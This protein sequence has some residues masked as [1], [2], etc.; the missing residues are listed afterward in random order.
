VALSLNYTYKNGQRYGGWVDTGGVY[1]QVPFL[2]N[3]GAEP[4]GKVINVFQ[5]QN[6]V[7]NRRFQ[8]TNREGM[9]SKTNAGIIQI[10]KRMSHNWQ[11]VASAVFTRAEGRL[12]SSL[13]SP[14]AAQSAH[15]GGS[16]GQNPNDLTNSD[17]S[18]IG[19]RPF[20]GKLQLVYQLPKGFLIGANFLHQSGRPWGR[21][22]TVTRTASIPTTILSEQLGD[23]RVGTWNNLDVRLQ[24]EFH[25]NKEANL[26]VFVDGL[27][28]LNGHANEGIASRNA[29]SSS[30]AYPTRFIFPRR[31]ML[32]AKVRF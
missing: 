11:M 16:F 5:L 31:V 27:N 28:I 19:E 1:K 25:F 7:A 18:L 13:G 3:V 14:T 10:T 32:G 17:G 9:S 29:T 24:K 4:T 15:G 2:D 20:Q 30:F 22:L 12:S 26:A 21:Q 8:L 6:G 23:R